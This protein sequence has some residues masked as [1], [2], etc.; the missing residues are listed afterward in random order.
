MKEASA[1]RLYDISKVVELIETE[2]R[3]VITRDGGMGRM[4]SC[5]LMVIEFQFEMQKK[6]I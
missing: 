2:G 5:Y 3:T 6:F 1:I 4:G